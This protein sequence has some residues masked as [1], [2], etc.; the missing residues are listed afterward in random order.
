ML[1]E[2]CEDTLNLTLDQYTLTFDDGLYSQYYY[3]DHFQAI[4]TEKIYFISSNTICLDNKQSLCFP[5]C[6]E[7][8]KKASVGNMEDYMSVDQ[9]KL[10]ME[11]PLVTI[12]GHSHSH[13]SLHNFPRMVDKIQYIMDDT[14]RMLEWF[15]RNLNIHPT[16]FCFP[17]N[18]DFQGLYPAILK[19]YGFTEFYGRERIPVETLQLPSIQPD[20]LYTS[21]A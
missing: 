20:T 16:S 6:R 4:P 15:N 10:M 11:D 8:H 18:E 9:I 7:A 17:Y 12:G 2:I 19:R 21:P 13:T 3:F 5:S 1:H 14:E